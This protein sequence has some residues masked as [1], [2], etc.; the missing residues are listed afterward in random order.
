MKFM[1]RFESKI[2]PF[3]QVVGTN[4]YLMSLRDG[5]AIIMPLLI[6]GS[7]FLLIANFPIP[8]WT[9]FLASVMV[10]DASLQS[11]LAVPATATVSLMAVFV[12]FSTAYYYAQSESIG[13]VECGLTALVSWFLLMPFSINFIPSDAPEGFAGYTI[14]ALGMDW[15]GARGIFIGI[16]CAFGSLK[17][18]Q[19]VVK[20]NW[21]IK[22]PAG[23][24][25]TVSKAFS[26]LI[27]LSIVTAVFVVIRIIFS[28]TPWGNAFSFIYAFLQIPLTNLGGNVVSNALVFFFSHILWMFGIHGTNVTG[29]V[30]SPI[31]LTL[32]AENLEAFRQGLP[33]PNIVNAQFQ[34]LF[35]TYGGGGS[36]LSLVI[37]MLLFCHSKR[38]KQLGRLCLF[39]GLF[40]INEPM[41]FGLPLVLNPVMA[42]P[43]MFV[44]ILNIFATWAVM[45]IGLVPITNGI[46]MPWTTPPIISGFLSTDWRGGLFQAVMIA[47]GVVIYAPFIKVL[48]KTYLRDESN[49]AEEAAGDISFDDLDD[50]FDMGDL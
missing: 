38:V 5:F 31:L 24:P 9:A 47:A 11:L 32:S 29:S 22:M 28:A 1:D 23:V 25:P 30:Y 49:V 16:M 14:G 26:A 44:P 41:I 4:K 27:P 39:P 21:I 6:A 37:A 40:G 42:I 10:G 36:T 15:L 34:D 19:W 17:I 45:K 20:K 50:D 35:G 7:F 2:M 33:A 13:G 43:F 3:A 48:D 18:Y 12:V 8:A 46:N